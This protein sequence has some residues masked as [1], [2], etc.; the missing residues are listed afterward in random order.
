MNDLTVLRIYMKRDEK[1]RGEIVTDD[2][3]ESKVKD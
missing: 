3:E 1:T 2:K